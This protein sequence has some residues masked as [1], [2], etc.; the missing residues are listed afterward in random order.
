MLES[1][2]NYVFKVLDFLSEN[3]GEKSASVFYENARDVFCNQ[4]DQEEQVREL[5]FLPR[6][7][8]PTSLISHGYSDINAHGQSEIGNL[9]C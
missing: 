4:F 6:L 9:I 7:F 1:Y 8:F 2:E 3:K 5:L